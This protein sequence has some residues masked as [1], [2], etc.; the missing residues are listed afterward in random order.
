VRKLKYHEQKLLKKVN[1]YNWKSDQNIREIKVLRRY[2]IQDRE[3]YTKYNK[4]CGK[5]T[6]LVGDLRK[7]PSDDKE[8]I[9]M[10]EILL[11]KLYDM[12]ICK[13]GQSLEECHELA[14]STF[15]RRRLPVVMVRLRMAESLKQA[16]GYIEQ[17][18]IRVGPEV[19]RVPALH[20]TRSMEDHITWSDGS[21]IKRHIQA[22]A[23]E[24]DDF[25]LLLN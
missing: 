1:L 21:K 22:S 16:V 4:L 25:D 24:V 18:Q 11:E 2:H 8:R 12:G 5:I 23:E 7:L 14:A 19:V 13:A 3:D 17:G 6:K 9:K 15:C 20:V 10:T